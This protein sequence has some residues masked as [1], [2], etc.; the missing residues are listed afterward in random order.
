MT[1]EGKSASFGDVLLIVIRRL[2]V[3]LGVWFG[4]LAIALVGVFVLPPQYRVASKILVTTNRAEIST[5]AEKPT[6]LVRNSDVGQSDINSQVEILAGRELVEQ[7][8]RGMGSTEPAEPTPQSALARS[9]GAVLTAPATLVGA[10]YRRMHELDRIP[11]TDPIARR[12]DQL[13]LNIDVNNVRNTNVVEVAFTGIDPV[14]GSDFVNRLVSGYVE[15]QSQMQ[16][17]SEAEKFFMSQSDLLRQKLTA[18]ESALRAERE[19][20]GTLAGQQTEL[21]ARLNEFTAELSRTRVARAEQEQRVIFLEG[22]RRTGETATPELMALEGKRAD[23]LGRYRP[24]SERVKEIDEQIARL[25]TAIGRYGAVAGGDPAGTD[26]TAARAS[27]AALKGK[28]TAVA[29][30]AEEFQR[31]TQ[32]LEAQSIDLARL[33]RQ[34]K[35]DEEAY[36]SYV[37]T[38]EESRLS[39]ALQ[40]SKMLRLTVLEPATIPDVPVSPK[41]GRILAVGLFGGLMFGLACG[42]LIDRFDSTVKSASDVRRWGNLEVLAVLRERA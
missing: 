8:L 22:I 41:R 37:R 29:S 1:E 36:L 14:W 39:N 13:R 33:E 7:A 3:I 12:A 10:A 25:R 2:H 9:I 28:E 34:V 27:L 24:D 6:E 35:L 38:A 30:Q 18:S 20:A 26:L 40:Q 17:E 5:N 16:R 42:F 32:L 23:L 11:P 19:K 31:Q 21:H 4:V 15:Q